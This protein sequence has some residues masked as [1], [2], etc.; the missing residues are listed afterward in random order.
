MMR[1]RA[2]ELAHGRWLQWLERDRAWSR[3]LHAASS[4]APVLRLLGAVSLLSDGIV[5]Y[6]IIPALPWVAGPHGSACM[7]RMLTLGVVNFAIYKIMKRTFARPR[8][9]SACEGICARARVLDEHSFPSGH[10][11]H[12][13]A[14]GLVLCR[15]WPSLVWVVVP[16]ALLVALSRVVL[17][18]HYPSDVVA[19]AAIGWFTA[20]A[21]LVLM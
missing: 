4:H 10:T 13:V 9:C 1:P 3:A 12:A 15:Y 20:E 6:L 21:V 19:G 2:A 11:L 7:W 8:P 17:G 16:F 14:F 5:W 18:L